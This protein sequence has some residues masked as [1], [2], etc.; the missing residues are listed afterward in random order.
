VQGFKSPLSNQA[1]LVEDG[2]GMYQYYIK[3]RRSSR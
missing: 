3:V 1:R 2:Y